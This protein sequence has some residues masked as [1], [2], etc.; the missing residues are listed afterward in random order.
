MSEEF[1][2]WWH[3]KIETLDVVVYEKPDTSEKNDEDIT[4]NLVI[5][6]KDRIFTG[7]AA[8]AFAKVP[9]KWDFWLLAKRID[10]DTIYCIIN[11]RRL[12]GRMGMAGSH[13][14][15]QKGI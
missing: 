9:I 14:S 1:F 12:C 3:E 7:F 10:K 11:T 8:S 4:L 13:Q 15:E 5:V 2:L 6:N